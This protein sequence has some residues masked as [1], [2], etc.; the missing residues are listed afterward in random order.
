MFHYEIQLQDLIDHSEFKV[1]A[2][3]LTSEGDPKP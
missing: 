3:A 2:M 1:H